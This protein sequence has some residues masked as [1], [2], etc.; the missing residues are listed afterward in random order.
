MRDLAIDLEELLYSFPKSADTPFVLVRVPDDQADAWL[1]TL[2]DGLRRCYASD[3]YLQARAG[4]VGLSQAEVL[5]TLLPDPGSVMA[6]DFGEI[7]VFVYQ[8]VS[9]SPTDVIGPKKWRLKQD[10]SKPAP[11]SDVVQFIVPEWPEATDQDRILCSEVKTKSTDGNSTPIPSA[12]A[13]CEKDR[14]DRLAKTLVWLRERAVR[15]DL[16]TTL[17]AHLDRFIQATDHPPASREFRAVA[18]LCTS[19]L[20][21]EVASAPDVEPTDYKV[22]VLAVPDLKRR[23]EE[24]FEAVLASVPGGGS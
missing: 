19:V 21:A 15:E 14:I 7:L 2:V 12:I 18:V 4:E 6:G 10:R 16:G 20:D 3:D 17:I 22:V 1:E 11:Y 13:D 8:G 23:Y 5:A 24:L 9:E